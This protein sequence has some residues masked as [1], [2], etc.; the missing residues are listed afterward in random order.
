M[1]AARSAPYQPATIDVLRSNPNGESLD[2]L[3][4]LC[5]DRVAN[6][7]GLTPIYRFKMEAKTL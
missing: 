2:Q 3:R 4:K 1:G 6:K 7:V 5:P